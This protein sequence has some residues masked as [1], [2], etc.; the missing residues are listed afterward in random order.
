[1]R[2]TPKEVHTLEPDEV[3]VFGSNLKGMHGAGAAKEALKWGAEWGKGFGHYGQTYAIPTKNVKMKT[4][5]LETI[6][7]FVI[8][9][10]EYAKENPDLRFLVTP[11]G[12]GLAGYLPSAVA[13]LFK[14]AINVENIYLPEAFWRELTPNSHA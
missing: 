1:M 3:F 14:S 11:I 5:F 10:I 9:F 7:P 6:K 2:V 8:E 13:P 4:L 12:C